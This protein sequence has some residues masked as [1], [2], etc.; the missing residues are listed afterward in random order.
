MPRSRW[1]RPAALA[2]LACAFLGWPWVT[3]TPFILNLLTGG[4][5]WG[6]FALSYDLVLGW[7]GEI[8]FGH[9]LWFG[10][11]VYATALF[12]QA[13]H[14]DTFLGIAIAAILLTPLSLVAHLLSLRLRGAYFA[15]I[16]FAL[17]EFAHLLVENATSV[18][19]GTNGLTSVPLSADALAPGTLYVLSALCLLAGLAAVLLVR[20]SRAGSVVRAVRD[21]PTRAALFGY[22]EVWVK[23]LTLVAASFLAAVAGGLFLAYQG[24][25][26]TGALDSGTSFTVLLMAV[27]GGADSAWGAAIAG[28]LLYVLE[29]SLS[30]ATSHGGIFLG[31][32]YIAVVRF[33]PGGFGALARRLRPGRRGRGKRQDAILAAGQAAAE[34][35]GP[36]R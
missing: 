20:R 35:G 3:G 2:A 8:S 5:I 1:L 10:S 18:T 29:N 32:V 19:G 28:I 36:E 13:T 23:A 7:T 30:A 11:G 14:V 17:A 4:V 16:T 21:N 27:I 33:L 34:Q 12:L 15:M 25:A 6:L 9:A 31:G 24:M 26:F 22:S